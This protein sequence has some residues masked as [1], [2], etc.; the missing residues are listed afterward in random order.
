MIDG[1]KLCGMCRQRKPATQF[2]RASSTRDGL[3][4]RCKPCARKSARQRYQT[5]SGRVC[6]RCGV[7]KVLEQFESPRELGPVCKGCAGADGVCNA[8]PQP[9]RIRVRPPGR[10]EEESQA[11]AHDAL[12]AL[13]ANTAAALG[14]A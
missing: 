14:R 2:H 1:G 9:Q 11:L 13:A 5:K 12:D 4:S 6:S 3:Q 8:I 10:T 7:M